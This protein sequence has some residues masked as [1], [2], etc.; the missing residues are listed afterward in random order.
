MYGQ[1]KKVLR[2][3]NFTE[4][5]NSL[6]PKTERKCTRE[7]KIYHLLKDCHILKPDNMT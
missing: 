5:I 6:I 3:I 7:N 2:K 1:R 4:N